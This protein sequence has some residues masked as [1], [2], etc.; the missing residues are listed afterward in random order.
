MS[1]RVIAAL[2]TSTPYFKIQFEVDGVSKSDEDSYSE[3]I[4]YLHN[5]IMK[6]THTEM[7]CEKVKDLEHDNKEL[8]AE[9][10]SLKAMMPDS[11]SKEE[12]G[13]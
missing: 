12:K 2:I 10:K 6:S 7:L 8:T 13:D 9:N 5:K 1:D 11:G 3:F 4:I